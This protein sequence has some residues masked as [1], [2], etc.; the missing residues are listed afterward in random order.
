MSQ[1]SDTAGSKGSESKLRHFNSDEA[2]FNSPLF[3]LAAPRSFSSVISTMI[4]QHPQMYG[5][6]EMELFSARTV[7][8]WWRLCARATFP[9]SHGTL[10]AVGQLYF[11]EQ[12]E[13]SIRL[14]RGWLLRRC[15]W[16]TGFLFE[17]LAVK[18]RPRTL[19]EKSTTSVYRMGALQRA[20]R[21]DPDARF[22]HLVRHPRGQ[23]ESVMKFIRERQ[24]LDPLPDG[25]WLL[26]LASFPRLEMELCSVSDDVLDP[27]R[28]WYT[29]NSTICEFL[30]SV[31]Q[32]QQLTVRGEDLLTNTEN[33]MRSIANWL[34]LRS[35]SEAIVEMM[36]PERSPFACY[37]PPGARY[38]NDLL[39]LEDPRLRPARATIHSLEEPLSWRADNL[40]FFV[41]VK[42]LAKQFGYA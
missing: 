22:I 5:L 40:G 29:L 26:K 2:Q 21:M 27:Q 23:G 28:G 4:G 16:T 7:A 11:G 30:K 18:A 38:G 15:H 25:H 41:Q 14:A 42:E 20:H 35:D 6:P 8:E 10:R 36:H 9:R 13:R 24:K 12:T 34:G 39:F 32:E 17:M 33:G 1:I 31:P 37:G 19:V 3:I